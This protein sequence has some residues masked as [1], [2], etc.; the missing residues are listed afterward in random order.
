MHLNFEIKQHFVTD[1][2]WFITMKELNCDPHRI[3]EGGHC[4]CANA[5]AIPSSQLTKQKQ[6]LK[7][8]TQDWSQFD[9]LGV[10]ALDIFK[11]QKHPGHITYQG[12]GSRSTRHTE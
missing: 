8:I 6:V 3:N 4:P 11:S 2:E 1:Q 10:A 5:G 9:T 12:S 7:R